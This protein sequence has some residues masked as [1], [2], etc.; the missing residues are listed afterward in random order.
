MFYKLSLPP[1]FSLY[2]SGANVKQWTGITRSNVGSVAKERLWIRRFRN[3]SCHFTCLLLCRFA[4]LAQIYRK[5]D[6]K[7]LVYPG[8]F[9]M[10]TGK[11]GN[12]L[13]S[14]SKSVLQ[15]RLPFYRCFPAPFWLQLSAF[16]WLPVRLWLMQIN[17]K[18]K[19]YFIYKFKFLQ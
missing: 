12:N 13:V 3:T 6:C 18:T 19:I 14:G 11:L 9:N 15:S 16:W 4:E 8:A 1:V 7:L 10:T 5:K 17:K 2:S